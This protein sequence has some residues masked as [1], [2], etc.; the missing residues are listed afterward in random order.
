MTDCALAAPAP[1]GSR[2][3][4][5][6]RRARRTRPVGVPRWAWLLGVSVVPL[7]STDPDAPQAWVVSG[8]AGSTHAAALFHD[9]P[10]A[11]DVAAPRGDRP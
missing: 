5:T 6:A 1:A 8:G 10:G 7:A 11:G 3:L 2:P 9:G 4:T